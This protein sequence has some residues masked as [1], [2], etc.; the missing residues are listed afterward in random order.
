MIS[1]IPI[2]F[3]P[4]GDIIDY[5]IEPDYKK[6]MEFLREK[7]YCRDRDISGS[8]LTICSGRK[9]PLVWMRSRRPDIVAHE[10][11]HAVM[12]LFSNMGIDKI[13][14]DNEELFAYYVDYAVKK[15]CCR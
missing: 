13:T 7:G 9:F 14:D 8:G 3:D 1:L 11:I 15:I 4:T 10:M 5:F 12:Y 2:E 6:A